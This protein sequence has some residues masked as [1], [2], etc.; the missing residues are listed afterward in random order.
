MDGTVSL[1]ASEQF[2]QDSP[3]RLAV[4]IFISIGMPTRFGV[5][6]EFEVQNLVAG[7]PAST[8]SS[9]RRCSPTTRRLFQHDRASIVTRELKQS[10]CPNCGG[11][12]N[13]LGEQ[14][15]RISSGAD[16]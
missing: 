15:R 16:A 12:P 7:P 1:G 13:L 3:H 8:S 5:R 10:C 11:D 6:F 14:Y 2:Y 4:F 9:S